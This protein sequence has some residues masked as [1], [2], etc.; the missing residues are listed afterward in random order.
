VVL[1][2]VLTIAGVKI[3]YLL[4]GVVLTVLMVLIAA[5]IG[6]IHGY[7]L[8]RLTD[9]FNPNSASAKSSSDAGSVYSLS[10]AETAIGAG[11][12]RGT[13]LFN[14]AVT[15][16]KYVPESYSDSIFSAVGEQ[17]GFLGSVVMLGLFGL[18]AARMF[19]AIQIA[20]DLT[21]RIIC[22]GALAF[23]VF[24]V[25][26][27]VGMWIGLMPIT[28]IPLPF[29]SYGGSALLAFFAAIGLVANVEM[30]RRS[31]R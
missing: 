26:Q 18:I 29:I 4:I 6:L 25:F 23:L 27:N 1:F 8:Q 2:S 5:Q 24:S 21:G 31:F 11:G 22:G 14:G 15:S 28:G 30:R 7:Q 3:R 16:L 19:R 20:G 10:L 9:F 13:G 12:L 17:L